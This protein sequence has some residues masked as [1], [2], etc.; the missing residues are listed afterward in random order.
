MISV[1]RSNQPMKI[2]RYLHTAIL[3]SDLAGPQNFMAICW[4][5]PSRNDTNLSFLA[6][7]TN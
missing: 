6:F 7:G 2:T 5:C 4:V 3:V 1:A